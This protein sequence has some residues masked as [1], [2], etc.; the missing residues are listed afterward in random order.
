MILLGKKKE[1]IKI[2]KSQETIPDISPKN[3]N[4][5]FNKDIFFIINERIQKFIKISNEVKNSIITKERIMNIQIEHSLG[6][7]IPSYKFVAR[8][9]TTIDQLLKIFMMRFTQLDKFRQLNDFNQEYN[10]L[11]NKIKLKFG[12][13]TPVEKFF[14]NCQN[15]VVEMTNCPPEIIIISFS[16]YTAN[17]YLK[18]D[19]EIKNELW[20]MFWKDESK[21]YDIL[22]EII[23]LTTK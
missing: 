23:G 3:E 20:K 1:K 22:A 12:D 15:P 18:L 19:R 14:K 7:G 9:G 17:A 16:K 21:I 8:Y 4:L 2:K 6:D 10:F 11:Y 5:V 13:K